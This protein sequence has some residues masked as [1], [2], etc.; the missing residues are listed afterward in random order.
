MCVKSFPENSYRV[1]MFERFALFYWSLTELGIYF[2]LWVDG[3][4]L[5][6]KEDPQDIDVVLFVNKNH[7]DELNDHEARKLYA[8][9]DPESCRARYFVDVRVHDIYEL[10]R[11]QQKAALFSTNHDKSEKGFV[12]LTYSKIKIDEAFHQQKEKA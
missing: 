1:Q 4:F 11:K 8:L 12:R 6:R 5:T 2:Q 7:L 10:E 9:I 3:S